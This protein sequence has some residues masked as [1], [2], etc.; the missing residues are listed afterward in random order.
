M[1]LHRIHAKRFTVLKCRGH[2][3]SERGK[4]EGEDQEEGGG[5]GGGGRMMTA[6]KTEACPRLESVFRKLIAN[7]L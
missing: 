1:T 6:G 2:I 5:G 7:Q 4:R 3:L